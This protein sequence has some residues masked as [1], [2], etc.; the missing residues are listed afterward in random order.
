MQLNAVSFLLCFVINFDMLFLGYFPS[1]LVRTTFEFF[2][3]IFSYFYYCLSCLV[4]SDLGPLR[5]SVFVTVR[6]YP[7]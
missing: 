3:N 6:V 4:F 5:I 7:S 1:S 2:F